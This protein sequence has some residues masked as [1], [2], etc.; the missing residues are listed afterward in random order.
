MGTGSRFTFVSNGQ[1]TDV[2]ADRVCP[3]NALL[4]PTDTRRPGDTYPGQSIRA[5]YHHSWIPKYRRKL[6]SRIPNGLELNIAVSLQYLDAEHT[7]PDGTLDRRLSSRAPQL[8]CLGPNFTLHRNSA[9]QANVVGIF[10]RILSELSVNMNRMHID[11][12]ELA[13]LKAIILF[14]SGKS[15]GLKYRGGFEVEICVLFFL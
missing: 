13:C 12:A 2:S 15:M 6:L 8:M 11:R 1:Q 5:S 4:W 9:Q 3:A 10:D 7:N 14:N